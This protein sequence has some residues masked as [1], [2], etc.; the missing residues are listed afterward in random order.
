MVASEFLASDI[1]D[2]LLE[3]ESKGHNMEF[4]FGQVSEDDNDDNECIIA[5]DTET[6]STQDV[7]TLISSLKP[8][9]G[10]CLILDSGG[11]H[12]QTR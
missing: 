12:A 4:Q 2:A 8:G 11:S 7:T 3:L 6:L 10:E 1:E 9:K 5:P